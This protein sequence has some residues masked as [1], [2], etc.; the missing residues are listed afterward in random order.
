MQVVTVW[1]TG[2]AKLSLTI[3]SLDRIAVAMA[4]VL[5]RV[6]F[7]HVTAVGIPVLFQVLGMLVMS[8]AFFER[9]TVVSIRI[10]AFCIQMDSLT[11]GFRVSISFGGIAVREAIRFGP[12]HRYLAIVMAAEFRVFFFTTMCTVGMMVRV[13]VFF[14]GIAMEAFFQACQAINT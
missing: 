13:R 3:R 12:F 5:N 9:D 8:D 6:S 4:M 14:R 11:V 2:L 10:R 7:R 1:S